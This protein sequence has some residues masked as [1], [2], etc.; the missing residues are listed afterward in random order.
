MKIVVGCNTTARRQRANWHHSTIN[1]RHKHGFRKF[2]KL[3]TEFKNVISQLKSG[4]SPMPW[5]CYQASSAA[6][7]VRAAKWNQRSKQ[8]VELTDFH[9]S[10]YIDLLLSPP[11]SQPAQMD[12][13]CVRTQLLLTWEKYSHDNWFYTFNLGV[14]CRFS[15]LCPLFRMFT[16]WLAS[17]VWLGWKRMIRR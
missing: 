2:P 1:F 8:W 15:T 7:D 16:V 12:C 17:C 9:L 6:Q 10:Q 5:L 11:L 13:A 14:L 3:L 4:K